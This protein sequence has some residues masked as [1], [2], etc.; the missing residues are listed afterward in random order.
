MRS[1]LLSLGLAAL[2]PT[3]ALADEKPDVKKPAVQP[4]K[5]VT[6]DRKTPVLYE[7]DIEPIFVNKC[8]FCHSGAVKEAKLDL[9]SY[10]LLM[11]GGKSGKP[12]VPGKS[13]ESR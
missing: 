7:K 12:I 6:L 9:S 5:V 10:E 2:L 11:R 13:A 8:L 3:L 4:I 1:S